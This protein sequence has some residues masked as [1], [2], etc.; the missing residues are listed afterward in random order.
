MFVFFLVGI[1]I[2]TKSSI[3]SYLISSYVDVSPTG[4]FYRT[5]PA[6]SSSYP[7]MASQSSSSY[8]S[9]A[10]QSSSSYPSIASSS[11]KQQPHSNPNPYPPAQP[12]TST[13]TS[14]NSRKPTLKEKECQVC[15]YLNLDAASECEMCTNPL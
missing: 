5:K 13:S 4:D 3:L 7:S 14:N 9:M 8:P 11:S 15:T 6:T 2:H 10:S 12:S 1:N